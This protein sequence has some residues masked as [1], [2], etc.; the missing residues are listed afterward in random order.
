MTFLEKMNGLDDSLGFVFLDRSWIAKTYGCD[1]KTHG[2]VKRQ[3]K[4]KT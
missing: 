3:V 1:T 4:E 2:F